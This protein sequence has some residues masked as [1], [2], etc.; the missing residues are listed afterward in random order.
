M[1]TESH[2]EIDAAGRV[3]VRREL[4]NDQGEH[5]SGASW[6]FDTLEAAVKQRADFADVLDAPEAAAIRERF[7]AFGRETEK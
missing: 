5:V 4:L 7:D 1:R 6:D 2:I 3:A